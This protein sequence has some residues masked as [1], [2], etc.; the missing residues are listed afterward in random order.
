M[1]QALLTQGYFGM[2]LS[3]INSID[4]LNVPA[5]RMLHGLLSRTIIRVSNAD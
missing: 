2:E 5:A 3:E 4:V 1:E